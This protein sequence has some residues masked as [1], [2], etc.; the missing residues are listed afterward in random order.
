MRP[1]GGGI[2]RR[3][4]ARHDEI[5]ARMNISLFSVKMIPRSVLCLFSVLDSG[6]RT[7]IDAGHAVGTIFAPC[8][9]AVGQLYIMKRTHFDTFPTGDTFLRC[10]ELFRFDK[11]GIKHR[12]DNAAFDLPVNGGVAGD[13]FFPVHM[14]S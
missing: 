6:G 7:V 11:Q 1:S 2:E 13:I 9:L 14:T 3:Q 4:R 10:A 8:R 5:L 12:I